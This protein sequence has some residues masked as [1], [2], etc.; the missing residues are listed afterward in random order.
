MSWVMPWESRRVKASSPMASNG[1]TAMEA[2][3]PRKATA[4]GHRKNPAMAK[5]VASATTAIQ[6]R[7]A[8]RGARVFGMGLPAGPDADG[9]A[10][11]NT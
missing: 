10:P 8:I 11:V 6:A 7:R 3:G 2:F 5:T 9:S 4:P 1:S